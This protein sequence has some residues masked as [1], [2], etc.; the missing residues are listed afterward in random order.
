MA[1]LDVRLL[2]R[3]VVRVDGVAVS[4]PKGAKAWGLLAYLASTRRAHPRSDLAELLFSEAADPLGALRWNL[5]AMR[6]LL[7]RPDALKGDTID[8]DLPDVVIDTQQLDAGDETLL[9]RGAMGLL[10]SGLSFP[11]SPRFEVWLTGERAR[12]GRKTASLLRE[13][14]LRAL[15]AGDHDLAVRRAGDLVSIDPLDEGHQALLIRAHAIG[16]DCSAAG[17][18][19]SSTAERCSVVSWRS[20]RAL[21]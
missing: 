8:L 11:D 1:Q 21:P 12:L 13:G 15:A 16:G 9:E 4:P 17:T 7:C 6:R 19:S 20:S 10:L 14:A 3:P 2:G 5:A 18:R